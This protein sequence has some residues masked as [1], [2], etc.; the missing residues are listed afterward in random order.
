VT[1]FDGEVASAAQPAQT[2]S[3]LSVAE[4]KHDLIRDQLSEYLDNSLPARE[5]ERLDG[6]LAGCRT[7]RAYLATLRATTEALGQLPRAGVSDQ[8]RQRLIALADGG[9]ER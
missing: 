4:V 7:C 3:T 9:S 1:L 2:A 8:V 5:R 6:H